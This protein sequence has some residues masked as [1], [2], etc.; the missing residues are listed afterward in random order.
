MLLCDAI[1]FGGHCFFA[2]APNPNAKSSPTAHDIIW[3]VGI[4]KLHIEQLLRRVLPRKKSEVLLFVQKTNACDCGLIIDFGEI[5][6]GG[7]AWSNMF[8]PSQHLN[9]GFMKYNICFLATSYPEIFP[10]K[11][12]RD[13][14]E[15]DSLDYL[16]T[17]MRPLLGDMNR[18]SGEEVRMSDVWM[19]QLV[20]WFPWPFIICSIGCRT[21][22]VAFI[23]NICRSFCTVSV[24]Y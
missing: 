3:T 11:A 14:H 15:P 9:N 16:H 22:K 5:S 23:D 10:S 1:P 6:W 21:S 17:F 2:A 12:R 13:K 20:D 18:G 4:C 24:K 8:A 7:R 19:M